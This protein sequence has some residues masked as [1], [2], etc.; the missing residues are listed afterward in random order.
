MSQHHVLQHYLREIGVHTPISL[1]F[2]HPQETALPD[3]DVASIQPPQP[4]TSNLKTL[5]EQAAQC[6]QCSLSQ[7]RSC[8][9]FGD[10]HEHA[11]VLLVGEVPSTEDSQSQQVF[12]GDTAVLLRSMFNTPA[13]A[14]IHCYHIPLIKCV[15]PEHR[16]PS[17]DEWSACQ[18]WLHQQITLIQPK[19]IVLMGRMAAQTVLQ[20]DQ[21]LRTLH[22][23][24]YN[25]QGIDTWVTYHPSYLLRAPRQ[26]Q[27]AWSDMQ[28]ILHKLRS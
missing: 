20:S 8:I 9:V 17:Q 24:W 27:V 19:V 18:I 15:T 16:A 26:K 7:G 28:S 23:H 22:G 6:E 5:A 25:Y 2:E 3:N 13:F 12:S 14:H 1:L 21:P 10:G 4:E 11:D